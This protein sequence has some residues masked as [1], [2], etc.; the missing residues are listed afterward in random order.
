MARVAAAPRQQNVICPG[1]HAAPPAGDFWIC[2]HCQRRFDIF[3]TRGVCPNCG[4]IFNAT[5]CLECGQEY[6][7]HAFAPQSNP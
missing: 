6:P 3:A 4:M 7:L 2:G 1:C 5:R